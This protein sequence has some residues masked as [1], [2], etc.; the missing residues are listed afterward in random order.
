MEFWR[1]DD[2]A[3]LRLDPGDEL[4]ES[5]RSLSEHGIVAAAITS[6]IGRVMD[7]EI[8]HLD[9]DGVYQKVFHEEAMELLTT[10]GNLAPGPDGPFTHIHVVLSDDGHTV[11]GGHLF[12]ATVAVT[13]EIHLRILRDDSG[14]PFERVATDNEFVRLSFCGIQD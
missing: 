5:I 13:A 4:H 14:T 2:D 9:A 8:G 7:T 3:F 6:G 1:D 12:R 11:R 10:E